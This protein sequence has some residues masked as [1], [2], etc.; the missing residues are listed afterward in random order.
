MTFKATNYCWFTFKLLP[1]CPLMEWFDKFKWWTSQQTAISA[2]GPITRAYHEGL[3]RGPIT[4]ARQ[5]FLF[6]VC[7]PNTRSETLHRLNILQDINASDFLCPIFI[8]L[9]DLGPRNSSIHL[10]P[11]WQSETF[12]RDLRHG[13]VSYH[14]IKGIDWLFLPIKV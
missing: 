5:D 6:C 7:L 13:Q 8:V 3:S 4:G 11:H 10:L 1:L 2:R 9:F 12:H 14:S